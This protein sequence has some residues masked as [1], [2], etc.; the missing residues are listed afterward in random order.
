MATE[1][2]VIV[3]RIDERTEHIQTDITDL[4]GEVAKLSDTVNE[5]GEQLASMKTKIENSNHGLSK[6]QTVGIGGAA[7][8]VAAVLAVIIDFFMRR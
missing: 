5:H 4:K 6:R 1:L 8:F 3:G 2:E 7:G